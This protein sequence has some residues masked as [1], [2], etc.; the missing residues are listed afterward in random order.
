MYIKISLKISTMHK[1]S[2][3]LG[4]FHLFGQ[5]LT[6]N[7]TPRFKGHRICMVLVCHENHTNYV[8]ENLS[9]CKE[10]HSYDFHI[11]KIDFEV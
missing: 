5:F 11:K 9:F 7:D 6:S 2:F 8:Q 3:D 1:N 4:I 10:N